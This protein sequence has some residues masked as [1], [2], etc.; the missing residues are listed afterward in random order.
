MSAEKITNFDNKNWDLKCFS[1]IL[2]EILCALHRPRNYRPN[3]GDS[4]GWGYPMILEIDFEQL[5]R[6]RWLS[7]KAHDPRFS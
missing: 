6:N 4:M 1:Y 5:Y 2:I 3:P 7:K